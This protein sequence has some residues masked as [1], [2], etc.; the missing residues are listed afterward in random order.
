LKE[1]GGGPVSLPKYIIIL[2]KVALPKNSNAKSQGRRIKKP[3][4][5][6]GAFKLFFRIISE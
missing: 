4:V 5:L 3:R 2:F 1:P 6:D